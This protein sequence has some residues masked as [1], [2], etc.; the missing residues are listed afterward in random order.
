MITN[1]K[2]F[3]IIL[4]GLFLLSFSFAC[5]EKN[6][7]EDTVYFDS[8]NGIRVRYV[9]SLVSAD[10]TISK[11]D[12]LSLLNAVVTLVQNDSI[13]TKKVNDKGMVYFDNL[14]SGS[15]LVNVKADGFSTANF[16]V[17]LSNVDSTYIDNNN[18]RIVST[19]LTMFSDEGENLAKISGNLYA[20]QDYTNIG[21][22]LIKESV[23]LYVSIDTSE[24]NS[25]ICNSCSGCITDLSYQFKNNTFI[26]DAT[27]YYELLVP[28]SLKK[29][30]IDI[31][32]DDI[33]L[34]VKTTVTNEKMEYFELLTEQVS[35]LP[36]QSILMDLHFTRK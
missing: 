25:M 23:N 24:I 2:Q 17:N 21:E 32:A 4:T 7:P 18:Y 29:L 22:E 6:D 27:G 34:N 8:I 36:K 26:S 28:A 13:V 20:E 12:S 35:V 10:N 16:V 9:I 5:K 1:K 31:N 3:F 14:F 30:K 15:A 33:M 11:S 19:I